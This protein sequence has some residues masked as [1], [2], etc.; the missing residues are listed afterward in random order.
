[1]I[2]EKKRS[3][4]WIPVSKCVCVEGDFWLLKMCQKWLPNPFCWLWDTVTHKLLLM[5]LNGCIWLGD[6]KIIGIIIKTRYCEGLEGTPWNEFLK[7]IG[8]SPAHPGGSKFPGMGRNLQNSWLCHWGF[9]AGCPGGGFL[10]VFCTCSSGFI[11]SQVS[12]GG[13]GQ[14]LF[15]W[16]SLTLQLLKTVKKLSVCYNKS[17][18]SK[19]CWAEQSFKPSAGSIPKVLWFQGKGGN[20]IS[21]WTP[22][23]LVPPLLFTLSCCCSW[24]VHLE[25]FVRTHWFVWIVLISEVLGVFFCWYMKFLFVCFCRWGFFC[26]L[27]NEAAVIIPYQKS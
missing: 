7:G 25:S 10:W 20:L 22:T 1:M 15:L 11:S 19:S 18:I 23:L 27:L 12:W 26:L 13:M 14:E 6:E 21:S 4:G 2:P 24:L 3:R 8:W 9:V 5:G 16:A 17:H